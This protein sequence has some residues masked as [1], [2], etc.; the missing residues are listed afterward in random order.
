MVAIGKEQDDRNSLLSINSLTNI[1]VNKV[2]ISFAELLR[3]YI[4]SYYGLQWEYNTIRLEIKR[5]LLGFS[6][7]NHQYAVLSICGDWYWYRKINIVFYDSYN[8]CHLLENFYPP[9]KEQ[10]IL[11]NEM[12][13]YTDSI[14]HSICI[15]ILGTVDSLRI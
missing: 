12:V 9:C 14:I 7:Y 1:F 8:V 13:S 6:L 11:I 15:Y 3:K 2:W 5:I 4:V 10:T